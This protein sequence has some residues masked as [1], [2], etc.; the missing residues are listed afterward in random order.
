MEGWA[1]RITLLEAFALTGKGPSDPRRLEL[2][3]LQAQGERSVDAL[4][5]GARG[6]YCVTSCDAVRLLAERGRATAVPAEGMLE[7]RAAGER[8]GVRP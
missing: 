2:L 4:A 3:E 7:R 6:A 8:V 5:R 1:M